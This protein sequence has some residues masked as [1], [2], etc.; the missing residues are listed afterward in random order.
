MPPVPSDVAAALCAMTGETLPAVK[1]SNA[2]QAADANNIPLLRAAWNSGEFFIGPSF[3]L[4]CP[5]YTEKRF[6]SVTNKL[7]RHFF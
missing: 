6:K 7:K 4:A 1:T 2:T 5:E 3:Q